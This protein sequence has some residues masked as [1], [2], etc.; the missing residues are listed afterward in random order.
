MGREKRGLLLCCRNTSY[1]FE[2]IKCHPHLYVD[3]KKILLKYKF[4]NFVKIG[5]Y[6]IESFFMLTD[7]ERWQKGV[8][9]T[10]GL[11]SPDLFKSEG[12]KKAIQL[13]VSLYN[14]DLYAPLPEYVNA[15]DIAALVK[16]YL[17]S[18]PQPL[19]TS[20]LHNE[21]CGSCFSIPQMRN[22][23]KNFLQSIT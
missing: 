15:N 14:Q 11:N 12:N 7:I 2:D 20:D 8:A 10:D 17:A 18:V 9:S 19:I 4:V 16:C 5:N 6:H 3:L 13:F 21:V 1:R 23:L 22:I